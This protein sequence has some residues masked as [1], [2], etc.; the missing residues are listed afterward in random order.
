MAAT[1]PED[2]DERDFDEIDHEPDESSGEPDEPVEPHVL[3]TPS[4]IVDD[5]HVKYRVF[6]G[7]KKSVPGETG[8]VRALFNRSRRHVG[9][10]SEVH[11]VRGVS[12]VAHHGESIGIVGMNGAGKSTLLRAVAGLMPVSAGDVYV[13]GASALLGVNAA[14]IKSL[15]GERNIMIGGLALGLT[16]KQVEERF[17]EIVEFAGLQDFIHLPMKAYSSGMAARLRFAISTAAVP[18]ILMI[19]EALATG[20]AA[21]RARSQERIAQIRERAGTVFLVSHSIRAVRN[22]CDRAIWLDQGQVIDDGP[23]GEVMDRYAAELR[24]R[25]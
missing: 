8:R 6:G 2:F 22:M 25:R 17:D 9:A 24:R 21:F 12:F 11:A 10:I 20:D 7:R 4:V 3:G 16:K 18:D 19:D 1:N 14:L 13:A 23:S 5:V 15:T